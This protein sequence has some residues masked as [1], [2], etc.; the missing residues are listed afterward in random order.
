MSSGSNFL[1]VIFR[2]MRFNQAPLVTVCLVNKTLFSSGL[3]VDV[4]DFFSFFFSHLAFFLLS[5][6]LCLQILYLFV[7][8]S[9][10]LILMGANNGMWLLL[11]VEEDLRRLEQQ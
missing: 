9:E 7:H 2:S 8:D 1:V 4:V 6:I 11:L 10:I 3:V 5:S